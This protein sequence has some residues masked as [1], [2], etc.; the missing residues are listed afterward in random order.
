MQLKTKPKAPK[1]PKEK[2]KIG[3]Q[4]FDDGTTKRKGVPIEDMFNLAA[5]V[6]IELEGRKVGGYLLQKDDNSF[7]VTFGFE[8]MGIHSTMRAE[9]IDPAEGVTTPSGCRLYQ[10]HSP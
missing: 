10:C 5:M 9:Q 6:R 4:R 7:M 1:E 8:C 2:K 3:S